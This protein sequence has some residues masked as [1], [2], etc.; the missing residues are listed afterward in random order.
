MVIENDGASCLRC[1]GLQ[2]WKVIWWYNI[3]AFFL[4][5]HFQRWLEKLCWIFWLLILVLPRTSM[6]WACV[7]FSKI[8]KPVAFWWHSTALMWFYWCDLCRLSTN[9]WFGRLIIFIQGQCTVSYVIQEPV[10]TCIL[11]R[12]ISLKWSRRRKKGK[13]A[14]LYILPWNSWLL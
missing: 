11:F 1:F 7:Q 9:V 8:L 2:K 14:D 6:E 5:N 3:S 4:P 13:K 10:L 12:S